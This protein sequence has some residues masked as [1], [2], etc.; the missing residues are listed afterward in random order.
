MPEP[1]ASDWTSQLRRGVLELC[2]LRVLRDDA[3]YGYEI[4]TR[5]A[6]LGPLAAGENTLYP[7]LRRLKAEHFLETYSVDSP[8]GPPRLYYR[9]TPRGRERLSSLQT[10]W[11]DMAR[12]VERCL[13]DG[14]PA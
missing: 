4:V 8:A 9:L 3:S 5:L 10:E 14:A 13:N 11:T 2:V 6:A 1:N 7:L 12:A